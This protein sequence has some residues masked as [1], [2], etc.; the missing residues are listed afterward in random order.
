M[1]LRDW[2]LIRYDANGNGSI[3]I[4]ELFT[5]ID[6]YFDGGISIGQFFELIDL[7]FAGPAPAGEASGQT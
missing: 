2:L 5:A 6:D 4:S 7:Y 3:D 1:S